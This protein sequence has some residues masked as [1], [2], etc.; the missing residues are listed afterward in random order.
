M[1]YCTHIGK[2]RQRIAN[3]FYY[4]NYESKRKNSVRSAKFN[5]QYPAAKQATVHYPLSPTIPKRRRRLL[6]LLLLGLLLLLSE[7]HQAG[8][9]SGLTKSGVTLGSLELLSDSSESNCL[10]LLGQRGDIDIELVGLG[11]LSGTGVALLNNTSAAGEDDQSGLVTL[12]A[13]D[14]ELQG[15]L[16]LVGSSVVNRNA[17]S[18]G[19]LSVD[20]SSLQLL[21]GETSAKLDLGVVLGVSL[22]KAVCKNTRRK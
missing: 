12:E 3:Q 8:I 7:A 20:A 11:D 13:L 22:A 14:V 19:E 1:R 6:V 21:Q 2:T 16:T 10:G 4:S 18:L 9:S 15:L 17:N 5:T